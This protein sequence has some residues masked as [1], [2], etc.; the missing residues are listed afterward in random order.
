MFEND[1]VL[2]VL[3]LINSACECKFWN[4]IIPRCISF[5]PRTLTRTLRN[6][7]KWGE[8]Y[9]DTTAKPCLHMNA[10]NVAPTHR[11]VL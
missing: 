11:R 2:Y 7:I 10:F 8:M 1:F 4:L 5:T 9:K 3:R 6:G